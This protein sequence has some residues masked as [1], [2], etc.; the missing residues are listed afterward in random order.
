M[1]QVPRYNRLVLLPTGLTRDQKRQLEKCAK[2]LNAGLATD[3]SLEVTHVVTTVNAEGMCPRTMKYLQ[4]VLT[5]KWVVNFEWVSLCL[6]YK[7]HVCEEAFEVPGSSTN[8]DSQAPRLSR[9]NAERQ[10][11]GLFNGCHFFFHGTFTY[12]SPSKDD[13]VQ[14]VKYGGGV[15]LAREPKL[16]TL[17]NLDNTVPY[18]AKLD[19]DLANCGHYIVQDKVAEDAGK[20]SEGSSSRLRRVSAA[21]VMDCAARFCLLDTEG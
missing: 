14:L 8:P 19:T 7:H 9:L 11:P 4:A 5:G 21:W 12:P 10:L 18:H 3:F 6:E 16:D 1:S 15:V 17:D 2:L 13:L 20:S